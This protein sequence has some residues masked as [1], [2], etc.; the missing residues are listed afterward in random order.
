MATES[1]AVPYDHFAILFCA[2]RL[3][4]KLDR[5]RFYAAR[6]RGRH[7]ALS[8]AQ[9]TGASALTHRWERVTGLGLSV[10]IPRK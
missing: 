4:E 5:I 3:T 7:R 10:T 9:L 6:F 1:W 8:L 2:S